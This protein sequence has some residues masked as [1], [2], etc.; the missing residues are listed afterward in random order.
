M[1]IHQRAAGVA[2]IDGRVG[3]DVAARLA[4]I[5][6][7][8]IGPVD[9]A[10]DAAGD[11]EL[12][13]AEGA[14]KGKHGLAGFQLGRVS[15]DDGGKVGCVHLEHGKIGELVDAD[16]LRVQDAAIIQRHLDLRG[17]ID[18]MVVGDDVAVRRDDDAAS[19]A[20]LDL[21]LGGLL[22]HGPKELLQPGGRPCIWPS[23]VATRWS[24]LR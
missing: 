5:I 8:G 7:I 18:H 9:G 12:E 15:P 13:V 4:R 16:D 1:R 21:R 20:M 3:L 17:A 6:R 2:G 22:E 11:R 10:D 24:S 19:H 23:E 14:A